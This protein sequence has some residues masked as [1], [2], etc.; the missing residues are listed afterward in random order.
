[1][2]VALES[3]SKHRNKW[4]HTIWLFAA[5]GF[6]ES[7]AFGHLGAFLPILLD[8]L[9]V[10]RRSAPGWIGV[11]SSLAFVIGLPLLPFW[12]VWADRYGR[13]LIIIRSSVAAAAMFGLA[14]LSSDVWM[15]AAAR[16]LGGFVLGNTGV[17]MAVQEAITPRE[18]LG[19]A[20]SMISAGSPVGM[21]IGPFLGGRIVAVWSVR[22]LLLLDA[23]LTFGMACI[24]MLWL[25][26]E[27]RDEQHVKM[28]TRAGVASALRAVMLDRPIALLFTAT[29][30]VALGA[31]AAQ[32]YVPVLLQRMYSGAK[33][34]QIIGTVFTVSGVAMAVMTPIIG[35]AGDRLGHLSV[36]RIVVGLGAAGLV[37]QAFSGTS[38]QLAF[39][40]SLQ[41]ACMGGAGA[42]TMVLL[43]RYA[44]AKNRTS[45]LTLSLLPNQLS[46]F[47]GPL[48]GSLLASWRLELPF[49]FGAVAA[50]AGLLVSV[51]LSAAVSARPA[52]R[53]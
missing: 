32:P 30:I 24:L 33:L 36:W 48:A 12:G 21:A 29:F 25:K 45:V 26:E 51:A 50:L 53:G 1:L 27:P 9:G 39:C 44:D 38:A 31:S 16:L 14:G 19:R 7:L 37:G 22:H 6:V 2:F 34:A 13:K 49:V 52:A 10:P 5:T 11:L 15:L 3:G 47:L 43:A 18:R 23:A 42:L 4:Q 35:G 46:W 17:M 8:E 40:R 20:V 41:A 28:S